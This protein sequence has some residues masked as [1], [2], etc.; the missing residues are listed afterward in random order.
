MSVSWVIGNR[1]LSNTYL[2][3]VDEINDVFSPWSNEL[4]SLNEHN[5]TDQA[6][7]DIVNNDLAAP[8]FA[9]S[10]Y[11]DI[12]ERNFTS[13]VQIAQSTRWIN[14][15][16]SSITFSSDGGKALIIYSFQLVMQ[17]YYA[18]QS[19]LNFCIEVDGTPMLNGMLG[20]GDLQNDVVDQGFA[21]F[22]L[23]SVGSSPSFKSLGMPLRVQ[24]LAD[25]APGR[26]EVRLLARNL[27]TGTTDNQFVCNC[28]G[29]V[30]DMWA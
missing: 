30:I 2:L 20:S 10:I 6:F 19:G 25:L 22:Y 29:I 21:I 15:P 7:E 12:S 8:D 14:V 13:G 17:T 9:L 4:V 16:N 28:E 11:Q 27:Y 18:D 23:T 5:W 26:H 3:D 24:V 1:R